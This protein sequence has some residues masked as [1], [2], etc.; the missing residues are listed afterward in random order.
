MSAREMASDIEL[1][2]IRRRGGF[3]LCSS[4]M[5]FITC[6][7]LQFLLE[8]QFAFQGHI[9]LEHQPVR[10]SCS[11]PLELVGGCIFWGAL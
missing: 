1:L 11:F 3:W 7:G 6:E 10:A 9:P 5:F 2:K 8:F 4:S